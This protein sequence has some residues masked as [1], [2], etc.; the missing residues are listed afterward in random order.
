MTLPVKHESTA[1][2]ARNVD[3]LHQLGKMC[4]SSGF[5]NDSR[6]AAQAMV[7]IAAGQELGLAPIQSMTGIHVIKNRV[8]LSANLMAALLKKAGYRWKMKKFDAQECEL[9]MFDPSGEELG[10]S[11]FSMKDAQAAKLNTDNWKKYPRNM[12]F[13]RAISNAARW[14]APEV[15]TGCYTPE[16]MGDSSFVESNVVEATYVEAQDQHPRTDTMEL[17]NARQGRAPQV[18]TPDENQKMNATGE[19]PRR[20]R[21]KTPREHLFATANEKGVSREQLR[22]LLGVPSLSNA[23]PDLLLHMDDL[24]F[25]MKKW[26]GG[27]IQVAKDMIEAKDIDDLRGAFSALTGEQKKILANGKDF[28]KEQIQ[29][30]KLETAA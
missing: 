29:A 2:L 28:R 15:I 20:P 12:L 14:Y 21:S 19:P 10:P 30:L 7:K 22:G 18:N 8:T 17:P 13:A 25:S 16:E 9:I 23:A 6:Q 11:S 27:D 24:A 26:D 5:F 1:L 4:S 3:E